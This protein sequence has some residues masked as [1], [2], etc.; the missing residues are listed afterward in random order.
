MISLKYHFFFPSPSLKLTNKHNSSVESLVK[1]QSAGI[2]LDFDH[3]VVG[4]LGLLAILIV[5]RR[6]GRTL[7][8]HRRL[9]HNLLGGR[10]RNHGLTA[11]TPLRT[12]RG[13]V[14]PSSAS[15]ALLR[16][17]GGGVRRGSVVLVV[18]LLGLRVGSI[19]RGGRPG[20]GLLVLLLAT[21]SRTT[22]S[23]TA[24]LIAAGVG[25]ALASLLPGILR[26][27]LV[28]V[29]VLPDLLIAT[30]TPTTGTAALA[31]GLASIGLGTLGLFDEA[32][33]VLLVDLLVLDVGPVEGDQPKRVGTVPLR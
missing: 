22:S 21:S 9:L 27:G 23:G 4:G 16:G 32:G 25:S 1:I 24:L 3:L 28:V 13:S 7:G 14:G 29:T 26:R 19:A 6:I 30:A 11:L 18:V 20:N 8:T 12:G 33:E 15:L 31:L 5:G 2:H 17:R 10:L